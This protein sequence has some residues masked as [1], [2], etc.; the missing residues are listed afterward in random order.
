MTKCDVVWLAGL[1]EGEGCFSL[2]HGLQVSLNMTD[3]DV[4]TRAMQ[5]FPGTTN[6]WAK[7]AT[8]RTKCAYAIS[9][10]GRTAYELMKQI[11]PEMGERRTEKI[12]TVMADWLERQMV[13][14]IACER[15]FF[16]D[17]R[18]RQTCSL[19][20]KAACG[21]AADERHNRNRRLGGTLTFE[22]PQ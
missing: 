11:L 6:I 4:V 21:R 7:P 17:H 8:A 16:A 10:N 12:L 9:W 3:L 19:E 5:V 1:L 18:N 15:E 20:C 22:E 2:K 13:V 14:C